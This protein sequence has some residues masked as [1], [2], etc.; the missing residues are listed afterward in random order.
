MA[1]EAVIDLASFSLAGGKRATLR[2]MVNKASKLGLRV[3]PYDR[4]R[5]PDPAI[6]AELE[7]ISNGWVGRSASPTLPSRT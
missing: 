5:Q 1:E 2:A 6:D 3:V 4:V 7:T